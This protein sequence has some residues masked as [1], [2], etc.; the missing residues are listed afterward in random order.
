MSNENVNQIG[1]KIDV[2]AKSKGCREM[3]HETT[4]MQLIGGGRW[5][6]ASWGAH[7]FVK[8]SKYC[9]R[10]NVQGH[11]FKGHIYIFLNFLDYYDVYYC[12]NRGTI[13]MIDTDLD[14]FQITEV[15]DRK[16]EYVP[17]YKSN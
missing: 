7:N 17:E 1:M 10:F 2:E 16:V 9:L 5:K 12:T 6:V 13:K 15:I 4:V 11:H 8:M 14:C 3:H